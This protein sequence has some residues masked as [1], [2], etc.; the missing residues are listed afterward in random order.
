MRSKKGQKKVFLWH[1]KTYD[2]GI[3]NHH[4]HQNQHFDG[5]GEFD[6]NG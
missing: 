6:E 4:S 1:Y 3:P 5:N 2:D